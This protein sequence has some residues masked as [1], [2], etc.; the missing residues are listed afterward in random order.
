MPKNNDIKI[1]DLIEESKEL[2]KK[3]HAN[4]NDLI[5]LIPEKISKKPSDIIHVC[6]NSKTEEHTEK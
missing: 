1:E 6:N 5:N 3:L 2:R 4:I